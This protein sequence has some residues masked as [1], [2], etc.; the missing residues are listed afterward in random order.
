MSVYQKY[1]KDENN[2]IF[3]PIV[4]LESVYYNGI[5]FKTTYVN[6]T[7]ED[8]YLLSITNNDYTNREGS[9]N[10]KI[11]KQNKYCVI[12]GELITTVSTQNE[13]AHSICSI[14]AQCLPYDDEVCIS[15]IWNN[16]LATLGY[17]SKS[18]QTLTIYSPLLSNTNQKY[19][20]ICDTIY[21][22]NS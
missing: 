14:P 19:I 15:V 20:H 2:E 4:S 16:T 13:K 8:T 11:R 10:L 12:S 22:S 18:K 9:Y 6:D 1:L 17:I 3:S 5:N 7:K 21:R